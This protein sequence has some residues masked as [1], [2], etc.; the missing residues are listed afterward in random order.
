MAKAQLLYNAAK[1][2]CEQSHWCLF[3]LLI[4]G[5]FDYD[6]RRVWRYQRGNENPYIEEEQTTKWLKEKVQKDKQSS[7]KYTH[8]TRD[9]VTQTGVKP[10][11]I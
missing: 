10:E 5:N 9:R 11:T 7:T 1:C 8:K 3:S 2:F 6:V 4:W